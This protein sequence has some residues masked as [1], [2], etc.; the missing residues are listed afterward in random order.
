MDRQSESPWLTLAQAA[1]ILNLNQRTLQSMRWHGV[2]P[3][4]R[5]H[6]GR[7]FYH[8][9]DLKEWFVNGRRGPPTTRP[10][11]NLR[12]LLFMLAGIALITAACLP[13]HPLL[14]WNASPSVPIGLYRIAP[15]FPR[16]GELA[17]V[18]L[19]GPMAESAD[20][21]GYLRRSAYLLKPVAAVAGDRV[22]RFGAHVLVRGRRAALALAKDSMGRRMPAWHGCRTLGPGEF[23]VLAEHPAS[24]DSRY[25]GTVRTPHLA[26]RLWSRGQP[27]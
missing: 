10:K 21:R 5:R 2:G 4:F 13:K 9:G 8:Q 11:R 6:G 7:T 18:Q 15:G 20:R 27:N 19:T 12:P 1:A 14:I 3:S 26:M 22:C 25:F 23:F 17:L 16:L 24:F